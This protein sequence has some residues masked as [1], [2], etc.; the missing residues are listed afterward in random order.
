M[1]FFDD[2]PVPVTEPHRAHHPWDPP[3]AEFPG[4]VPINS[5]QFDRSDQAAI[6]ITGID[7]YTQG[8]EIFVTGRIR[9]GGNGE[10]GHGAPGG[11][12]A[13]RR[14]FQLGLQFSDG[15]K[16]FGE[17]PGRDSEPGGPI[18]RP[19]RGGG[20][21]HSH[22]SRWWAWPLPP[23]GPLEFVCQWPMLGIGETRVSLD[24]QLILD[25]ARRSVQLWPEDEG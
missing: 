1:S 6:A 23:S 3:E 10:A 16:V 19:L 12:P 9:P 2:A 18:L 15:R 13:A 17:R 24:A 8:F 25:A 11:G 20:S 22:F 4:I 21:E 14:S 7:V 5:L